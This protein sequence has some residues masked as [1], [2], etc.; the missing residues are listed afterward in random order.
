MYSLTNIRSLQ[1][2]KLNPGIKVMGWSVLSHTSL[3]RLFLPAGIECFGPDVFKDTDM[4]V[5]LPEGPTTLTDDLNLNGTGIRRICIP[6]NV[7]HIGGNVFRRCESLQEVT[8][9]PESQLRSI[10]QRAFKRTG[11]R[12]FC[13]PPLLETIG[14][15]AF[16]M[17]EDLRSVTLNDGLRVVGKWGFAVSGLTEVTFPASVTEIREDAFFK[18]SALQRVSFAPGSHLASVGPGAFHMTAL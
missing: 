2:L 9:A 1:S 17:C 4:V 5:F 8:F 15:G 14:E 18:C 6:K 16:A 3:K 10:G 13:A 12:K 7:V 11:L